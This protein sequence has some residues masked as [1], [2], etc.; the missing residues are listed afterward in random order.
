M[1]R[2]LYLLCFIPVTLFSQRYVS[3]Q[4][5]D[6]ED[7]EPVA[8]VTVFISN[9]TAGTTT[10]L[11]GHYRLTIP[12]EGSYD[13]TIS[14]VAY[15]PVVKHIE[16][17]NISVEFNIELQN[18]ELE[19]VVK[20]TRV[21]ARQRDI[22]LFWETVLGE[23]PSRQRMR[24]ANPEAVYYY[25]NSDTK[26]LTVTSREPLHI[27][28]YETGYQIQYILNNFTHNYNTGITERDQQFNFTE[29]E[30]A[31]PKQKNKWEQKRL[32]VYNVSLEKFIRSLYN[33]SLYDDGFVLATL[34]QSAEPDK[35]SNITA[36]SDAPV[37]T[38]FNSNLNKSFQI[39]VLNADSILSVISTDNSRML[40]F[41]EDDILL[42][43]YG[44]PVTDRDLDRIRETQGNDFLATG[45]LMMNLLHG[46]SIRIFPDGTFANSLE[47]GPINSL[48]TITALNRRIPIDYSQDKLSLAIIK[49][50][51]T[52]SDSIF[53]Y[54]DMQRQVFPQ[55]KLHLHT[56]RDCYVPGE[57]IWF[58]AYVADAATHQHSTRS[59]YVYAELIS[60]TDTLIYRVMVRPEEDM[61]YGY[62]PITE[63]VPEGNYTLRA[64]TRYMEN[65]GDD[66]FFK[67]NITITPL[68]SK[69]ESLTP[70]PPSG[71]RGR[72][73]KTKQ[74]R[75]DFDVSFFPEGGNL[76]EGALCKVAF[77]ALNSD[78]TPAT[79]AGEIV[80][81][82]G[83]VVIS[84]TSFYAGMGAFYFSPESGKKYTLKCR[85][86]YGLE[87]RFDLPQPHPN[88]YTLA[89]GQQKQ[90]KRITVEAHK[91]VN[92]PDIPCYLLAHCRGKVLH[93]SALDDM[94]ESTVFPEEDLPAGVIHLML[95]DEQMNVLSERLVF[96]KNNADAAKID[97]RTDKTS[98]A[99]REKVAV[100]LTLT[101][102]LDNLA[103]GHL[104][105]AVTDDADIAIDST[106]TILST[107]LLSSELKGYIDNPAYYLQDDKKSMTALDYLM[108]TH[109]WRRYDVPEVVKGNMVFPQ[110][111]Y[112]ASQQLAGS[113]KSVSLSRPISDSE[114]LIVVEQ[115]MGSTIT[116]ESGRFTMR[117]FEYSDSTSYFIQALGKKGRNRVQLTLDDELFPLL[118]HTPLM[119]TEEK[120]D[121]R[122]EIKS[123]FVSDAFLTKAKQRSQYDEDI[124][125]VHLGE[126]EVTAP[127]IKKEPRLEF[128]ANRSAESTIRREQ[129]ERYHPTNVSD[130]LKM[131]G[132]NVSPNGE[133]S[134][135][136]E[137]PLVLIDGVY[138]DWPDELFSPYDSPVERINVN[139]I[140]SIDIITGLGATIF[141]TR[142]TNGAISITTKRD[143]DIPVER[144]T[145]NVVIYNPLGFQKP[146]AFYSPKYDT[147]EAKESHT[148]DYRTTLFWKPDVVIS[149]DHDTAGFEFYTSDFPTTYSVVIEGLTTDGKIIRQVKKIR[150]E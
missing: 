126:V 127:I 149:D 24:V 10:D 45:G 71:K 65:L 91:S 146:A 42:I 11:T 57:K 141:G 31:N 110:I 27:I 99:G 20:E 120:P 12:S 4:I 122:E 48:N 145:K 76:L 38:H 129:I 39:T 79:I 108:M 87:K 6:A 130:I 23:K 17:G 36:Y 54:F 46:N 40:T 118:V 18:H 103:A 52:T 144:F 140:E 72:I 53:Q 9:T 22:N 113:V 34:R 133:I 77:K 136:G 102:A 106:I 114:V 64:Y 143:A 134:L 150:V 8:G 83:L 35:N 138:I 142:G 59:R 101:D 84:A 90:N 81:E 89:V 74:N 14:H 115:D 111:P 56:D 1:K 132:V 119:F 100:T 7:K 63:I 51:T 30:P 61:Y 5:T 121:L 116:D 97:F 112:Q 43:C 125:I 105:V 86:S 16:A 33:N 82:N 137:R 94:N 98:Y 96:N 124:R 25:F 49:N 123:S 73:T 26:I 69:G 131:A 135:G 109:G 50:E 47:V 95:F 28:N 41:P 55:E 58:K 15:Q 29:L 66:Y 75:Q 92:A 107:L 148:P 88:A 3:G 62:I 21:R 128:W 2:L 60:P 44:R 70:T 19:E 85:N 139:R 37:N 117:D 93:F 78:G 13:L 32:K 147:P 67:K 80:D 104:S 68:T